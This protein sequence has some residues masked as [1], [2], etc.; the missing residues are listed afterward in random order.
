MDCWKLALVLIRSCSRKWW[1]LVIEVVFFCKV[2]V[3]K[4]IEIALGK[5]SINF[6]NLGNYDYEFSTQTLNKTL[7]PKLFAIV[8]QKKHIEEVK[9]K[10]GI[11]SVL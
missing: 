6:T 2:C 4:S 9:A 7:N 8:T 10:F 5:R 3:E 1:S 11:L